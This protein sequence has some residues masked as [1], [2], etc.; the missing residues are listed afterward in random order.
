MTGMSSIAAFRHF[1]TTVGIAKGCPACER[2]N[3][4]HARHNLVCKKRQEDF[5]RAEAETKVAAAKA[6]E[7]AKPKAAETKEAAAPSAE[8]AGEA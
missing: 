6:A 3:A 1:E 4:G 2:K 7:T 5:H 8:A